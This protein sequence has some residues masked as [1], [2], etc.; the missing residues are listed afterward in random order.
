MPGL[1]TQIEVLKVKPTFCAF[2]NELVS[3]TKALKVMKNKN[4]IH[5]LSFLEEYDLQEKP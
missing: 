3:Y 1:D 4:A 2:Y 5:L